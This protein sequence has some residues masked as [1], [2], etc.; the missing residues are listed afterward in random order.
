[1][2]VDGSALVGLRGLA[3]VH[4]MVLKSFFQK[5]C[6]QTSF[7]VFHYVL[8]LT[9]GE[10]DVVGYLQIPTFFLLSGFFKK[11]FLLCLCHLHPHRGYS[12]KV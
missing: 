6:D 1:M 4:V 7:Q 9:E 10:V 8:N 3:C 11:Y 5:N 12:V 2:P